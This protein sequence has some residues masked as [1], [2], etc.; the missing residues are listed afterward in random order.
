MIFSGFGLYESHRFA[1]IRSEIANLLKAIT[2]VSLIIL[3]SAWIFKIEIIN[4]TF[5]V[6]FISSTSITTIVSRLVLRKV[7]KWARIHYQNLRYMLIVGTNARAQKFACKIESRPELGYQFLGFVSNQWKG[8]GDLDKYG[9]DLVSNLKDFNAYIRDN[10]VDE[11]IIAL[12]MKSLYQE[13]SRIF[14]AS[15]E[16]GIIVRNLSDIFKSKLARS[17]TEYFEDEPLITH[18]TGAMRGWQVTVKRVIDIVLS[19]A[20]LV[21]LSPLA[22]VTAIAIKIDSPGQVHFVQE[23]VGLNKRRFRLY[24]FR[25]MIDG[26]DKKQDELETLNEAGGP[27]FKM[28]N[29]PRITTVGKILRKTSIDQLPQLFNVLKGDMSLVGRRPLPIRDYYGF[30]RDWHRRRFSVRPGI[31]CLWQVSGRS[32]IPFEKWMEL[33]M[34]YIDK[35]SLL[36]D[37]A[38]LVK[39]LP[40][41]IARKG[42]Q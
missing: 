37:F 41:V 11:V 8:N 40:A 3:T 35:W 38:I 22:L 27:V 18:Y 25:T 12:P 15:E 28:K 21:I 24:K 4:L 33:D 9:W 20:L 19:A 7:L 13:A 6:V 16:Q 29:D 5:L 39:T 31:T 30:N 34:N 1:S 17:R 32:S 42:A 26:A 10:I 23:R 2:M 36:L 14:A